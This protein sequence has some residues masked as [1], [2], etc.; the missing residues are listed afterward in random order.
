MKYTVGTLQKM[1]VIL[2]VKDGTNA[3]PVNWLNSKV[4]YYIQ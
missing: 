3:K 4:Q 2:T 1:I